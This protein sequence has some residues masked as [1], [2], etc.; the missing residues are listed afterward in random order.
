MDREITIPANHV[1]YIN[2]DKTVSEFLE[3]ADKIEIIKDPISSTVAI[4]GIIWGEAIDPSRP[5]RVAKQ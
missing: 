4:R 5:W 3:W 2:W 1:R